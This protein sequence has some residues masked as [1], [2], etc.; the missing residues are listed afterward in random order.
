MTYQE[1]KNSDMEIKSFGRY[2]LFF[3]T[4]WLIPVR[5]IA[6]IN[7]FSFAFS[8]FMAIWFLQIVIQVVESSLSIN[9]LNIPIIALVFVAG[10]AVNVGVH[11]Y[12]KWF[13]EKGVYKYIKF[14]KKHFAG[15]FIKDINRL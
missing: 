3:K 8:I 4:F 2:E 11:F 12:I 13:H 14:D 10:I 7:F 1:H 6:L 5:P 15:E 9:E